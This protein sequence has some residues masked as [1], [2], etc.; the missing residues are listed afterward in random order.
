ML[1]DLDHPL[2]SDSQSVLSCNDA[3]KGSVIHAVKDNQN[4]DELNKRSK[5]TF[6]SFFFKLSLLALFVIQGL[7]G[8]NLP[9]L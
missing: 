6:R 1:V 8:F 5:M 3:K 4:T 7:A 9:Y 2:N